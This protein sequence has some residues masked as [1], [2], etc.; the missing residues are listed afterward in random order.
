MNNSKMSLKE[1]RDALVKEAEEKIREAEELSD[2][3][4]EGFSWSLAYGM[5]GYY[6]AAGEYDD[7]D[8]ED[9]DSRN[10]EWV[11]SSANC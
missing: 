3:L 2:E 11:S 9:S 10:G 4:G 1:R 8:Y 7:S 5:G 6:Q